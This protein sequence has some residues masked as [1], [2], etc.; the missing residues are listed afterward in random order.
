MSQIQDHDPTVAT[1]IPI[2]IY[3]VK[4][5]LIAITQN[6]TILWHPL[7]EQVSALVTHTHTR[8]HAR[9]QH[10]LDFTVGSFI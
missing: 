2:L 6:P 9:T 1:T 4:V 10:T 8:A 7:C 3:K 5:I